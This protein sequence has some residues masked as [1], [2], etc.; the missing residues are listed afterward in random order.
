MKLIYR[1]MS[2]QQISD[3]LTESLSDLLVNAGEDHLEPVLLQLQ[4]VR[5]GH[6]VPSRRLISL[7]EALVRQE[8]YPL[9]THTQRSM[10]AAAH[11]IRT[12]C[13]RG[14][15]LSLQ[16]TA[17]APALLY[18]LGKSVAPLLRWG[19]VSSCCG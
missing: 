10:R 15:N 7:M 5:P 16:P 8:K 14:T 12:L 17:A 3:D 11:E 1:K 6:R 18:G 2:V 9:D 4:A 13:H 19:G